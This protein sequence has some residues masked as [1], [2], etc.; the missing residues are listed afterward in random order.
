MIAMK[1]T[2]SLK[3]ILSKKESDALL[4]TQKRFAK[5][6]NL[7][8]SHAQENRCWNHVA[9]HNKCYYEVRSQV[10]E[11][12]SQMVCNALRK[13]CTSYKALRIKKGQEVP[14]IEFKEKASIHYCA[15]TFIPK[16][17]F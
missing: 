14:K 2:I 11:L 16:T 4:K 12:G 10:P 7:I 15:R 8:V 6:C 13:V 5:G 1:R 9:L 3:L 17:N